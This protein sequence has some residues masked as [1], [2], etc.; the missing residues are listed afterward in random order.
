MLWAQNNHQSASTIVWDRGCL[1]GGEFKGHD[2]IKRPS[3]MHFSATKSHQYT[4]LWACTQTS[5]DKIC[6]SGV[7][8]F[9]GHPHHHQTISVVLWDQNLQ[10]HVKLLWDFFFFYPQIWYGSTKHRMFRDRWSDRWTPA[11]VLYNHIPK[12]IK[13]TS[14][15][16]PLPKLDPIFCL[17]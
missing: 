11:P 5:M 13:T 10:F 6:P 4:S 1:I 3:A 7:L 16:R 15:P 17:C 12:V 2:T 8:T 9:W 14:K